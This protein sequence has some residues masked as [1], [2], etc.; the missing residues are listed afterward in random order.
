[1]TVDYSVPVSYEDQNRLRY[2]AMTLH[3]DEQEALSEAITFYERFL[4][5]CTNTQ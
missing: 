4:R 5:S 2:I 3:V 1:V